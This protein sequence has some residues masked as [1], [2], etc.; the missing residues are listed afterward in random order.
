MERGDKEFG[1]RK[2]TGFELHI[3]GEIV[4]IIKR[5]GKNIC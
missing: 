3:L 1:I 2:K 4:S 5:N